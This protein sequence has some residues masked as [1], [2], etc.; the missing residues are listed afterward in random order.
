MRLVIECRQRATGQRPLYA[1]FDRLVMDAK[2][3]FHRIERQRLAVGEQHSRSLNPARRLAA[4]PEA[5]V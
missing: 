1:T 2:A 5:V 3:A 4:R